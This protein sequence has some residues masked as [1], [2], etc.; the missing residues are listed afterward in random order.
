MIYQ[1]PEHEVQL[2]DQS[3]A[4]DSMVAGRASLS[5]TSGSNMSQLWALHQLKSTLPACCKGLSC[6]MR[7]QL[8]RITCKLMSSHAVTCPACQSACIKKGFA[9][10]ALK[11]RWHL[12]QHAAKAVNCRS[13]GYDLKI[14]SPACCAGEVE[15]VLVEV[16]AI[17]A[18]A[19]SGK[20]SHLD[21][22]R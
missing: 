16:D 18:G 15:G 5:P 1:T 21:C 20:N 11:H 13:V 6:S 7:L 12:P 10:A 2:N 14:N 19:V 9:E 22:Y 4:W 8:Q 3:S 17:Q